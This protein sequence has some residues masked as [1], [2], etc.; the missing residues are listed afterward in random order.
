[1]SPNPQPITF[2]FLIELRVTPPGRQRAD[3]YLVKPAS[4]EPASKH[5]EAEGASVKVGARRAVVEVA[6]A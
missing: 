1:M 4:V 5:F 6:D 2:H 3:V